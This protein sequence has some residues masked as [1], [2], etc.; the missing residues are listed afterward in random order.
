MISALSMP[1]QVDPCDTEVAVVELALDHD[2]RATL[3][4]HLD[5]MGV[6]DLMQREATADSR[7][8]RRA[9]QFGADGGGRLR[10][11]RASGA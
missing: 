10:P 8:A 5:G 4:G 2:K 11:P 3:I 9:S 1:L 6:A 7:S